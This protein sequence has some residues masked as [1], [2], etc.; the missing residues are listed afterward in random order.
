VNAISDLNKDFHFGTEITASVHA[1]GSLGD[2]NLRLRIPTTRRRNNGNSNSS[3]NL[4]RSK[5]GQ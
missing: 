5:L 4:E 2:A 3:A 1:T